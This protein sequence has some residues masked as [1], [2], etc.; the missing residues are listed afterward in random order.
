MADI[1]KWLK[2]VLPVTAVACSCAMVF[3]IASLGTQ[4]YLQSK[5]GAVNRFTV[6][7]VE[8]EIVEDFP[9]PSITPNTPHVKKVQVRSTG[10]NDC[11]VRAR[12]L[13]ASNPDKFQFDFNTDDWT[14]DG[15]GVEAWWYYNKVLEPGET[16]EP[17][18]EHYTITADLSNEPADN[19]QIY[20]YEESTQSEGYASAKEAFAE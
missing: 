19:L 9:D 5:D 2:R 7:S 4:S 3:S 10:D 15:D 14:R 6:G 18:F 11:Y 12:V 20:V 13:P 1:K 16:T 8:T 17:L